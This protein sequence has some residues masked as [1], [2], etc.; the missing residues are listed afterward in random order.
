V[1]LVLRQFTYDWPGNVR[2]LENAIESA[3]VMGETELITPEDLPETNFA[4]T[5]NQRCCNI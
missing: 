2:Q 4:T 5:N 3:M 1:K